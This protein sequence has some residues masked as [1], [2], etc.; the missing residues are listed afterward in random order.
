MSLVITWM[1]RNANEELSDIRSLIVLRFGG[2]SGG[3]GWRSDDCVAAAWLL[4]I[5]EGLYTK[6]TVDGPT[7]RVIS[8]VCLGI[9]RPIWR[10]S[11]GRWRFGS[12]VSAQGSSYSGSPRQTRIWPVASTRCAQRGCASWYAE[13]RSRAWVWGL[14][15]CTAFGMM[16]SYRAGWQKSLVSRVLATST[17]G[18]EAMRSQTQV[19]G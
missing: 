11:M 17:S 19:I 1:L 15:I 12:S 14:P 9:Y 2:P 3:S 18:P 16:K 6:T 7:T 13:I 10:L 8:I 4:H 5:P